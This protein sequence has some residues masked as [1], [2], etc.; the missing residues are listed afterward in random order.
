MALYAIGDIQGCHAEFC[1]LL[2]LIGFSKQNDHLWLVGDLVNRG[3]ESLEVLREVAALGE[4]A[5]TVLGNHDFHLLT[6]AAG[7]R[8]PHRGDTL[9]PILGAPDR[10]QLIDWLTRR[11]LVICDGRHLLVHAG[12]LPQWTAAAAVAL[13]REVEATLASDARRDFLG[14][15]YGDQS[16]AELEPR[17][18][19]DVTE[20]GDRE[21]V[22]AAADGIWPIFFAIVNRDLPVRS[23]VNSCAWI[24]ELTGTRRGPYYFFSIDPADHPGSPWRDGTVYLLPGETFERQPPQPYQGVTIDT[25]QVASSVRVRPLAKLTVSPA[26]FPFLPQVR[27]HDADEM[28]RRASANPAGFPWLDEP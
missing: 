9:D 4:C 23:L 7:H 13:S 6:I 3:P 5:S 21:A 26:D 11:P 20:F 18:A 8:K 16:L 22:Y 15:L 10:D 25:T 28:R 14:A 19:T 2:D 24:V 12:L 27:R 1:Q 17:K